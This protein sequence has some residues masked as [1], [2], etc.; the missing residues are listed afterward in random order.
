MQVDNRER[1]LR[2]KLRL[3]QAK[4]INKNST[5]STLEKKIKEKKKIKKTIKKKNK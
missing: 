3:L 5:Y 2:K 1:N 4:Q